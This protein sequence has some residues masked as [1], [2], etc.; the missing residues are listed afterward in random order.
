M[1]TEG[2]IFSTY[3][4]PGVQKKSTIVVSAKSMGLLV[5]ETAA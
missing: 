4:L 3:F 5:T 2:N 1:Y